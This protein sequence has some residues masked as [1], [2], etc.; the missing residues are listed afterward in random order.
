MPVVINEFEVVTQA[1]EGPLPAPASPTQQTS[2][3]PQVRE[4]EQIVRRQ[5]ER[6]ARVRAH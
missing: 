5:M 6:A 4:I 2:P 1:E 3:Q